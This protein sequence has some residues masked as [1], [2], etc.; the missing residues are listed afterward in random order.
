MYKIAILDS[1]HA[2]VLVPC[3]YGFSISICYILNGMSAFHFFSCGNPSQIESIS[4][5][6]AFDDISDT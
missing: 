2:S 5:S 6:E 3:Q 4:V 1:G